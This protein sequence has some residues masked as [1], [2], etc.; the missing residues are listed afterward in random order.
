[1]TDLYTLGTIYLLL[2]CLLIVAGYMYIKTLFYMPGESLLISKKMI[3]QK[4]LYMYFLLIIIILCLNV[5]VDESTKHIEKANEY[6][7]KYVGLLDKQINLLDEYIELQNKYL[8]L[9]DKYDDTLIEYENL[10]D[11]HEILQNDY[12]ILLEKIK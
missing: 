9:L 6:R 5:F 12:L 10:L 8:I 1:M 3:N 4:C 2:L 11:K 7:G